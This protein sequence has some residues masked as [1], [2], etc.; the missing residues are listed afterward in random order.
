MSKN[1]PE[2][3]LPLCPLPGAALGR[4]GILRSRCEA[5]GG[6]MSLPM[7]DLKAHYDS[8]NHAQT[9]GFDSWIRSDNSMLTSYNLFFP[10]NFSF[11]L[12]AVS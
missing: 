2:T 6:G 9:M 5:G 11:A 10:A 12:S 7:V 4:R 3:S 8:V 1:S